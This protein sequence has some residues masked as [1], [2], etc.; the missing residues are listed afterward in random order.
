MCAIGNDLCRNLIDSPPGKANPETK[1][2]THFGEVPQTLHLN[3]R[4]IWLLGIL[5]SFSLFV[6][7]FPICKM[8]NDDTSKGL[9]NFPL[10]NED[11]LREFLET[12]V[13]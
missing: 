9:E 7:G 4:P 11:E 1:H 6:L 3:Q 12:R 10:Q 8:D 2:K 13:S 5:W